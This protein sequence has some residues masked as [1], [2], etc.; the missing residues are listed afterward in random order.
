MRQQQARNS[1]NDITT[2]TLFDELAEPAPSGKAGEWFR[3]L[4]GRVSGA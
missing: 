4:V 3:L 2:P 1:T